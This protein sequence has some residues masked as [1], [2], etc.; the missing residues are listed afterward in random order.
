MNIAYIPRQ[1]SVVEVSDMDSWEGD[2]VI[3]QLLGREF[4]AYPLIP[5]E[6]VTDEQRAL[7]PKTNINNYIGP[8]FIDIFSPERKFTSQITAIVGD[9]PADTCQELVKLA[10]SRLT[11][12]GKLRR[13]A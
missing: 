13:I 12:K 1:Y 2:Y 3:S 8:V 4:V 6:S 7:C 10:E 5:V 9:L 11:N